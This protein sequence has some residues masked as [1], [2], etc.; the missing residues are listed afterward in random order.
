QENFA[1]TDVVNYVTAI[2]DQFTPEEVSDRIAEMLS[3]PEINA[4]VKIIFQK[5][6]DL[7]IACPKNLGDW[8]F[9]GEYPTP[10]GNRVVNRA[11]INF[12]EGKNAR[13]Y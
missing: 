11:F 5:V 10:G 13:A 12:Y 7:H 9:T 2:Y 4:E 3:S 6:E 1:D 8:Y